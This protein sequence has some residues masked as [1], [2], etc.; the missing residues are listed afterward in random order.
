MPIASP[1]P[2]GNEALAQMAQHLLREL[3]A[4]QQNL[5]ALR[6]SLRGLNGE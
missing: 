1:L 5:E 6:L 4:E 3:K 2:K